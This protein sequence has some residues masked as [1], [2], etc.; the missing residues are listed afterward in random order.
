MVLQ[1][2]LQLYN[3]NYNLFLLN[4]L[5]RFKDYSIVEL[6]LILTLIS[7][8]PHPIKVLRIIFVCT[9]MANVLMQQLF[10]LICVDQL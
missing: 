4:Y 9:L 5:T 1:I 6:N 10:H 3:H 8:T 7:I 2:H